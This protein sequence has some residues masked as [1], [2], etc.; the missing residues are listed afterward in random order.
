M[1]IEAPAVPERS[2]TSRP[3]GWPLAAVVLAL[4]LAYLASP[5]VS[6]YFFTRAIRANDRA[7]LESFVDFPSLRQSLKQELRA[8]LPK[9]TSK[10]DDDALSGV[11]ARLGPSLI[12]Q[13]VDAFVT[14][15][16]LAALINDPALVRAAQSKDP[17]A[18][19]HGADRKRELDW[20]RVK[21]GAFTGV[22][23]FVVDHNGTKLHFRFAGMR[24]RLQRIQL[25]PTA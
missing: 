21:Q 24:W 22:R 25:T 4:V 8:M 13:L 18:I 19:V 10:K 7:A 12:D 14:P 1:A 6:F 23:E 9:S 16:G 11:V 2:A 5:Y 3:R 20:S 17:G 15:D